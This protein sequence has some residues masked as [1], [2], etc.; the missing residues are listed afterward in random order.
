MNLPESDFPVLATVVNGWLTAIIMILY[1]SR[2]PTPKKTNGFSITWKSL[3][4]LPVLAVI[5][6]G[7]EW[8]S[9]V[10]NEF[11]IGREQRNDQNPDH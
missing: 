10:L 6:P 1:K 11:M 3:I 8:Q 5:K 7:E 4:I 2:L 9:P